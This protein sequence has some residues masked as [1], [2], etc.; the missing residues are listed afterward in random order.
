MEEIKEKYAKF[1]GYNSWGAFVASLESAEELSVHM[2][3]MSLYRTNKRNPLPQTKEKV[4]YW[5][6]DR[7]SCLKVF[8]L[9]TK[10]GENIFKTTS[11]WLLRAECRYKYVIF[12]HDQ[13]T[14]Y[15]DLDIEL[16]KPNGE[17]ITR[18][19]NLIEL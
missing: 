7:L 18:E 12:D 14:G 1:Q 10:H 5:T 19:F 17:V 8:R 4:A 16:F 6:G 11:E 15:Y 9:F 13:W 3:I 2:D